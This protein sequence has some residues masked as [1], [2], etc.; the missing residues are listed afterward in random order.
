MVGEPV[1]AG[2]RRKQFLKQPG[3]NHFVLSDGIP[4]A[5]RPNVEF[6]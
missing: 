5:I 6:Y 2:L 1:T 3:L 4:A